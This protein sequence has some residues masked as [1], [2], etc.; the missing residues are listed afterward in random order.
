MNFEEIKK[1]YN[2]LTTLELEQELK[3]RTTRRRSSWMVGADC[4]DIESNTIRACREILR[5]RAI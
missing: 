1:R 2:Y 3:E 5:E 4:C